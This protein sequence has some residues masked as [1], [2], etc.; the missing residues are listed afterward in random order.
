L[1][2]SPLINLFTPKAAELLFA[3]NDVC[4]LN[5]KQRKR[6][7]TKIVKMKTTRWTAE[8][9]PNS[10]TMVLHPKALSLSVCLSVCLSL[11][12]VSPPHEGREFLKP[13]NL[14]S[15]LS[16]SSSPQNFLKPYMS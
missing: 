8:P 7:E 6:S 10:H 3:T 12:K 5:G 14:N 11:L 9:K 1:F 15:W 16:S 4:K 2:F 13:C